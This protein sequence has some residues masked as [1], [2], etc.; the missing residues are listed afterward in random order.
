[1]LFVSNNYDSAKISRLKAVAL[2]T[3]CNEQVSCGTSQEHGLWITV[4]IHFLRETVGNLSQFNT[5]LDD[6]YVSQIVT[7]YTQSYPN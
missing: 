4:W 7:I 5:I 3:S 1:M 6:V 2:E